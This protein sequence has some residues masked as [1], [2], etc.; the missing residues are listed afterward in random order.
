MCDISST[1]LWM[2]VISATRV[3]LPSGRDVLS[4]PDYFPAPKDVL[5]SVHKGSSLSRLGILRTGERD[6]EPL[7]RSWLFG[8]FLNYWIDFSGFFEISSP[9]TPCPL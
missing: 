8:N 3:V 9:P 2:A 7:S 5:D 6:P 1:S 4:L